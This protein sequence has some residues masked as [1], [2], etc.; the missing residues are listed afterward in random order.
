MSAGATPKSMIRGP[1]SVS[2]TFRVN[3]RSQPGPRL[4]SVVGGLVA[5]T[6]RSAGLGEVR[7]G[8]NGGAGV[9]GHRGDLRGQASITRRGWP[10]S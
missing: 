1:Y 6:G 7:L 3:P 5:L 10:S 4:G 9:L 2:S 8:E